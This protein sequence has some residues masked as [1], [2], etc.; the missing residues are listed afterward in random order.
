MNRFWEIFDFR[1]DLGFR[2]ENVPQHIYGEVVDP[3]HR[4][5]GVSL[6]ASAHIADM[7]DPLGSHFLGS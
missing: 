1:G 6:C 5:D 3:G 4:F 7:F 2:T